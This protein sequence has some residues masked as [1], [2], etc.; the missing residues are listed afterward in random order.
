LL[1]NCAGVTVARPGSPRSFRQG[2]RDWVPRVL[3]RW[4]LPVVRGC[5]GPVWLVA[6]TARSSGRVRVTPF[7][8]RA[9]SAI[10]AG[11]WLVLRSHP[12]NPPR[13]IGECCREDGESGAVTVCSCSPDT[14]WGPSSTRPRVGALRPDRQRPSWWCPP[15]PL[16]NRPITPLRR[17]SSRRGTV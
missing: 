12:A 17:H 10:R 14:G 3:G 16:A 9:H 2:G 8:R 1:A 5:C 4:R 6:L 7:R 15:R 13:E 11:L